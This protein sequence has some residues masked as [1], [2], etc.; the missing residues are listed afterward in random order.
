MAS[1]LVKIDIHIVF[2]IKSTSV[3]MRENDIPTIHK[4]IGGIIKNMQ[5][6]PI[7]IGGVA[8]HVHLLCTLPKDIALSD[9]V[10]SIKANSSRWIKTID[11]H[12]AHFEWQT[13][14]GAFSVSPSLLD[15]TICYINNQPEHHKKVS[16]TDEYGAFLK[17][18]NIDFNPDYIFTD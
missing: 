16:F 12:Y 9:F 1:T 3:A 18:Y 11:N 6:M 14:Y 17:A 7:C 5:S 4:Y 8:D 15:K 10:R 2:H 13:G